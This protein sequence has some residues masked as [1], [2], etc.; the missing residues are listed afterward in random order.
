VRAIWP[1]E[2]EAR[3]LVLKPDAPATMRVR[4]PASQ[5]PRTLRLEASN[6]FPLVGSDPRRR[7]GRLLQMDLQPQ[8]RL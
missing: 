1:G 4:L 6:D 3:Q 8:T 2:S 7:S 5:K